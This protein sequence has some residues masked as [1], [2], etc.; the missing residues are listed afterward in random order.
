MRLLIVE[1]EVDLAKA[2][3][4]GLLRNNITKYQVDIVYDG[5][6]AIDAYFENNYDLVIL[7]LNLPSCDGLDVLEAIRNDNLEMP[8]LILSARINI[9]DKVLGLYLGANDYLGKPFDFREL[10]AR[11]NTLLRYRNT[12]KSNLIKIDDIT[13]N[14][15]SNQIYNENDE[16]IDFT[17]KEL[18]IFA[19]LIRNKGLVF[20]EYD[21]ISNIWDEVPENTGSIRVH[22]N[23][24]RN[25]L[26]NPS[27]IKTKRGRGYYV[28]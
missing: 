11:V 16:V 26:K 19:F 18:E 17:N 14:I 10:E 25:K 27:I 9:D 20:N 12:I 21:L 15:N 7:D 6:E 28:E 8:V 24:I 13:L 5:K 3:E 4:K 1:D 23:G 2:I 22:I